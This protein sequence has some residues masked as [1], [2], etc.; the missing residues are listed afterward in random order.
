[1]GEGGNLQLKPIIVAVD[2]LIVFVAWLGRDGT[3]LTPTQSDG[4]TLLKRDQQ[5]MIARFLKR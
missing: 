2:T 4:R 5:A 1:M 3:A